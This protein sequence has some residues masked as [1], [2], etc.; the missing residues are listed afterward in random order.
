MLSVAYARTVILMC[1]VM[2][3]SRWLW[4]AQLTGTRSFIPALYHYI[5]VVI[6]LRN[7]DP[8]SSFASTLKITQT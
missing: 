3:K 4:M 7:T 2:C 1:K 6:F 8:L 5:I